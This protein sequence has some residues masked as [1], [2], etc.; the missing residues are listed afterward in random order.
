[1][2][3]VEGLLCECLNHGLEAVGMKSHIPDCLL[4][5]MFVG[6]VLDSFLMEGVRCVA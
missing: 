5:P 4:R 3:G 2:G 1:M 6:W